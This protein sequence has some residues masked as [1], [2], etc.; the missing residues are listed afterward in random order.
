LAR[1][2]AFNYREGDFTWIVRID[3]IKIN[4]LRGRE[5]RPLSIGLKITK[6]ALSAPFVRAYCDWS[7]AIA[8]SNRTIS[9]ERTTLCQAVRARAKEY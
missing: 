5:I 4:K 3:R 6:Q 2:R 9:F 8:Q 7:S 1:K